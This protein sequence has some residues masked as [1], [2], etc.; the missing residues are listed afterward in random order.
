MH[1][2]IPADLQVNPVREAT[3]EKEDVLSGRDW[4]SSTISCSKRA[5]Q[6][7][8]LS[9]FLKNGR[10]ALRTLLVLCFAFVL[11]L[12]SGILCNANI[13]ILLH[14][15]QLFLENSP[16]LSLLSCRF[17]VSVQGASFLMKPLSNL[18]HTWSFCKP[19]NNQI[20]VRSAF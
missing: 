14:S 3:R 12:I 11:C 18:I 8:W 6:M 5:N 9:Q 2:P 20:R 16:Q 7:V 1:I 19:K 10:K 13:N 4:N 15:P 17:L